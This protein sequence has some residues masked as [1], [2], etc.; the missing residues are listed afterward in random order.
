M[1]I[2]LCYWST[3]PN[4]NKQIRSSAVLFRPRNSA[5]RAN[6]LLNDEY[7]FSFP[8]LSYN[9]TGFAKNDIKLQTEK[10]EGAM[11]YHDI[12]GMLDTHPNQDAVDVMVKKN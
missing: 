4:T 3:L 7:H 8:Y 6:S 1:V 10:L 2:N 5:K 12:V 11:K 9:L